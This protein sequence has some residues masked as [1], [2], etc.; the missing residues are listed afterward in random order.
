MIREAAKGAAKPGAQLVVFPEMALTGYPVE[1]L[2]CAPPFSARPGRDDRFA[3]TCAPEGRRLLCLI[4]YLDHSDEST[5]R[6]GGP[7]VAGQFSGHRSGRQVPARYDKH[8]LPN[9]GVFDE[10]RYFVPGNEP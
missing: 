3:R 5:S 1:D 2:A 4:G 8:F 10:A 7:A 6:S 9:Y